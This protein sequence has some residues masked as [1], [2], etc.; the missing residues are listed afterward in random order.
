MIATTTVGAVAGGLVRDGD[1]GLVVAP[2]DAAALARA[3][4]QLLDDA[5]LRQRL[6]EHARA[7]VGAYTY[8]AMVEAFDRALQVAL[9]RTARAA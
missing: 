7:A 9:R 5:Q 4:S 3:L 8:D 2:G 6:G 1:T